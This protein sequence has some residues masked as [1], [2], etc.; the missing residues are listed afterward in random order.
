VSNVVTIDDQI[1]A[2]LVATALLRQR[3]PLFCGTDAVP[4]CLR[5]MTRPPLPP[6]SLYGLHGLE[7]NVRSR[8]F[9]ACKRT[10]RK[11][12]IAADQGPTGNVRL[13]RTQRGGQPAG[14]SA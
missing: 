11:P 1:P 5:P 6:F 8:H 2:W 14:P 10:G 13:W 9:T 4:K 12:P 7:A 3:L